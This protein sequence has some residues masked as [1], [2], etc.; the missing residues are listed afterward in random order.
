MDVNSR[1][2]ATTCGITKGPVRSHGDRVNRTDRIFAKLP[3]RTR[4]EAI[5]SLLG[6]RP[7]R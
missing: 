1:T 4:T 5:A 7:T 6:S 3:T 2:V